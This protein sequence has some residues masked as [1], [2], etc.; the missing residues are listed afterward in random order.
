[1]PDE[2][3]TSVL[4]PV[5]KG[6]GDVRICNTYRGVKLLELVMKILER[7]LEGKI[8]ELVNIDAMQFGF[9]PGIETIDAFFVV[10]M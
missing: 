6:K 1:M 3:K 9:M 4:V 5:F 10:R 2:W 8:R 7:V